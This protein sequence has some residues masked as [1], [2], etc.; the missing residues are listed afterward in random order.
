[1]GK[2]DF[3]FNGVMMR[4]CACALVVSLGLGTARGETY[5]WTG[6]DNASWTN[7]ANWQIADGA[8]GFMA[9]TA[10]PGEWTNTV[11]KTH[12][13]NPADTAVFGA[14]PSGRT[15]I[16]LDGEW[17]IGNV[18]VTNGAPAY[19]FGTSTDKTQ[20]L[21]LDTLAAVTM[22]A[23]V[24]ETQTFMAFCSTF[25]E[26]YRT[27]YSTYTVSLRNDGA[28][29]LLFKGVR[30]WEGNGCPYYNLYGTGPIE[31]D[32][33][34]NFD[35]ISGVRLNN[36]GVFT[37]GDTGNSS[38]YRP[39]DYSSNAHADLGSATRE[40]V[41]PAG[42]YM[43]ATTG[44]WNGKVITAYVDT[45]ISGGGQILARNQFN[46]SAYPPEMGGNLSV[47]AGKTLTVD[48]GIA[49]SGGGVTGVFPGGVGCWGTGTIVLNGPNTTTG[50][51]R[52]HDACT[53]ATPKIGAAGCAAEES[54]L[55]TGS[56]I[57][58][59][60]SG[61][62]KY[63]GAGAATTDRSLLTTNSSSA[64]TL[65]F[66]NAG[67][68][69]F[70]LD[71]HQKMLLPTALG[72]T[73]KLDAQT[74][75]IRFGGTF[76]AG[77]LWKLTLAGTAGVGFTAEPG[78]AVTASA[79]SKLLLGPG[80]VMPASFAVPSGTV[81]IGVAAGTN[82]V[83][84]ALPVVDGTLDFQVPSDASV[85]IP[86]LPGVRLASTVLLNGAAA[87]T[88]AT[89][90]LVPAAATYG[91]ATWTSVTAG[92]TWSTAVNW[93]DETPPAVNDDV[94]IANQDAGTPTYT[95]TLDATARV[96]GITEQEPAGNIRTLQGPGTLELG[97]GGYTLIT[98]T[99]VAKGA[100]NVAGGPLN[101]AAPVTLLASQRWLLG[102]A[103]GWGVTGECRT[104]SGDLS[105]GADVL[106]EILGY[107]RYRFT[108]GSSENFRGRTKVGALI[109]FEGTNQ[110]HRLGTGEIHLAQ[111]NL[112]DAQ[113]VAAGTTTTEP[114]L[115]YVFTGDQREATVV[116]PIRATI[117]SL[118]GG[119][120]SSWAYDGA[121]ICF[122]WAN[123][124]T[125]LTNRGTRLTLTGGLAGTTGSGRYLQLSQAW[126]AH[127]PLTAYRSFDPDFGT[128]V[129]AGDGST[130]SSQFNVRTFTTLEIA[131]QN[132]LGVDNA[133]GYVLVGADG[134]WSCY[135]PYTVA[136]VTLRPGLSYGGKIVASYRSDGNGAQCR[137]AT[138]VVGSAATPSAPGA[139]VATFTGTVDS[140][141]EHDNE[142]R[143]VAAEGTTAKFTGKVTVHANRW[144]Y[145]SPVDVVAKGR[146]EL[147][148][149]DNTFGTNLCV[150]GGALVLDDNAAGKLPV[151]LGGY[152]KALADAVEVRCMEGCTTSGFTS[153]GNTTIDGVTYYGKTI[154]LSGAKTVDGV[155][156]QPGD[157]VLVAVPLMAAYNGVWRVVSDTQWQRVDGLD[158]VDDVIAS[159]GLRVK[160][161]EGGT[162]GG[163]AH[164]MV[165]DPL[166]FRCSTQFERDITNERMS[167]TYGVPIF[168][169]EAAYEP[170]VAL[171]T[172]AAVTITNAVEVTDNKSAGTSTIG[173]ATAASS[174]F[175]GP[176]RLA[177][178]VH[179]AAV[180]GGTVSFTGAFTGAGD[181]I[182]DGA[183]TVDL[184]SATLGMDATNGVL[185]A[186]G[187][188]QVT[189]AQLAGRPLG[190]IRRAF[191]EGEG[192]R[193]ST[194]QLAVEGNLDL[195]AR[196]LVCAG[197][198][199]DD[200][201]PEVRSLTL[202]TCTGTLTLPA[203]TGIAGSKGHWK[204]VADGHT[205]LARQS[206]PGLAILFR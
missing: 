162:F 173:G 54:C 93:L 125:A 140:N 163:T 126:S 36:A 171:L 25:D 196:T 121:P 105:A 186:G 188:L 96:N 194:G 142:L 72:A 31:L 41:V 153:L 1:M 136:G 150:R 182:G 195:R 88:D 34:V 44:G 144:K 67:G 164:F 118:V 76:E 103:R 203:Q 91:A 74:A 192:W 108:T 89:G 198:E 27:P 52:I 101:F 149:K 174:C 59:H 62:L 141:N 69:A 75:P 117:T 78:V 137:P 159:R 187:T 71:S 80:Y 132:A 57:R 94:V 43:N 4:T 14:C 19:T 110:F 128:I 53:L 11:A 35:R 189:A 20:Y 33:T 170:D 157:F 49:P 87:E 64:L 22:S 176:V 148:N 114:G 133:R 12:G 92:G 39:M 29:T 47:A 130:I 61:T 119:G 81:A 202:A 102:S 60:A 9:A 111:E 15:T 6:A 77:Q 83:F 32:G 45:H 169:P 65:T 175:S 90:K 46:S 28:G 42:R 155:R 24:T 135:Y 23:G 129:L 147:A 156:V 66:A 179:L 104:F 26:K 180:E 127:Q 10:A 145:L 197:F 21:K 190:W 82:L 30:R 55:G 191:G 109:E 177:K 193:E 205:L 48:C 113:A 8:G 206:T 50:D 178:S 85:T 199:P 161:R 58:F 138:M 166:H 152:V 18:V 84:A 37:L 17:R 115:T 201:H 99:T 139:T 5:F 167:S 95:I 120:R 123:T 143:F 38:V 107:Q 124:W 98:N 40:I 86:S 134:Y 131:N 146:V 13:G 112:T 181:L 116:N 158:D 184:T 160:V 154:T 106:W 51:V 204:F 56:A 151:V 172:G 70:T 73:L 68:G 100:G 79:G 16:D 2:A 165:T 7:A 183:G 3:R 122:Q 185:A 63:T 200:D 168:H 97:A